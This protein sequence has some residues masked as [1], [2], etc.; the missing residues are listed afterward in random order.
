MNWR[1]SVAKS[2]EWIVWRLG[3]CQFVN[4]IAK[5]WEWNWNWKSLENHMDLINGFC[6]IQRLKLLISIPLSSAT[7]PNCIPFAA[8]TMISAPICFTMKSCSHSL[9]HVEVQGVE[10]M[11]MDQR[12]SPYFSYKRDSISISQG[13]LILENFRK[14]CEKKWIIESE[15]LLC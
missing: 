13:Q 2:K 8:T 6:L 5:S 4:S 14:D 7:W 11:R 1:F 15:I 10:V 3:F 9:L 12:L